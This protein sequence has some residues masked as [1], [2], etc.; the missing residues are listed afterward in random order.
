MGRHADN[1]A[2]G[3]DAGPADSA[4]DDIGWSREIDVRCGHRRRLAIAGHALRR[5][6]ALDRDKARTK[7]VD[8]ARVLIAAGLVDLA[9]APE[10]GFDRHD[11]HAIGLAAA[12]AATLAYQ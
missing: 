1:R 9:L 10:F 2:D 3:D 6:S 12:I 4:D 5:R 8:A 7:A 11:R